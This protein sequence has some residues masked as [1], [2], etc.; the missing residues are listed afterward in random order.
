MQ[1]LYVLL[2]LNF[3]QF[4]KDRFSQ[5]P[6]PLCVLFYW[7]YYSTDFCLFQVCRHKCI[8]FLLTKQD[9]DI[10]QKGEFGLLLLRAAYGALIYPAEAHLR[11]TDQWKVYRAKERAYGLSHRRLCFR[12]RPQVDVAYEYDTDVHRE[13]IK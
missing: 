3:I 8:S 4:F 5:S 10:S 11:S 7:L 9:L 6:L 2:F 13:A 12:D 1:D